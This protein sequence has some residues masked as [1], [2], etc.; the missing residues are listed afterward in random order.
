M[1]SRPLDA[2]QRTGLQIIFLQKRFSVQIAFQTFPSRRSKRIPLIRVMQV[3]PAAIQRYWTS[4]NATTSFVRQAL[5]KIVNCK[6]LSTLLQLCVRSVIGAP[7]YG[8]SVKDS[9]VA[10]QLLDRTGMVAVSVNATVAN[11]TGN[12][13]DSAGDMIELIVSLV[14]KGTTT[15]SSITVSSIQ[16]LEQFERYDA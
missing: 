7:A 8:G 4:C 2:R 5:R 14:N 12:V 15:L 9:D 11:D 6:M 13:G 3:K 10:I 1:Q 16:L